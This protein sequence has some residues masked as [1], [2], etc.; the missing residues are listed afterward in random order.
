MKDRLLGIPLVTAQPDLFC[1]SGVLSRSL[2][3]LEELLADIAA[4][5]PSVPSPFTVTGAFDY[6]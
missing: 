4:E 5:L 1:T 2:A 6:Y 3:W